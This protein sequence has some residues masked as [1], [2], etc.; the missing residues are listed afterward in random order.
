MREYVRINGSV[1]DTR[2]ALERE[3]GPIQGR[4]VQLHRLG[5]IRTAT[6]YGVSNR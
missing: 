4:Y 2:E 1:S 6:G 3:G 5:A